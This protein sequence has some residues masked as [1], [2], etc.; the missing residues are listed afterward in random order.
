MAD[1][2]NGHNLPQP[3]PPF[4]FASSLSLHMTAAQDGFPSHMNAFINVIPLDLLQLNRKMM[5]R[6]ETLRPAVPHEGKKK[7]KS[8][9]RETE[10]A[11]DEGKGEW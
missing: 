5:N 8:R 2:S 6:L 10:R 9:R 7:K 1:R 11:M 3:P 4:F